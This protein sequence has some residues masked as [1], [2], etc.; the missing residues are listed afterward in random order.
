MRVFS[1]ARKQ[2]MV[3]WLA[4]R[5]DGEN[6]GKLFYILFLKGYRYRARHR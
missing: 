5:S 4:A 2:N 1:P 6:Y 3:A